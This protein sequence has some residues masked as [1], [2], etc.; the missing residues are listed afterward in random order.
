MS[1]LDRRRNVGVRTAPR[2]VKYN[3]MR[4]LNKHD[5]CLALEGLQVYVLLLG[6][7]MFRGGG[8]SVLGR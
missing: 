7:R 3:L 2:F 6:V 4:M 8:S 5:E 1:D